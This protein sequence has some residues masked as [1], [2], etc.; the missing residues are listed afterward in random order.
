MYNVSATCRTWYSKGQNG[1]NVTHIGGNAYNQVC[2]RSRAT[3]TVNGFCDWFRGVDSKSVIFSHTQPMSFFTLFCPQRN[4]RTHTHT[5]HCFHDFRG[6]PKKPVWSIHPFLYVNRSKLLPHLS[7]WMFDWWV[8]LGGVM[9]VCVCV[10]SLS[11]WDSDV[12]VAEHPEV[13]GWSAGRGKPWLNVHAFTTDCQSFIDF[14]KH[15]SLFVRNCYGSFGPYLC[16]CVLMI[17]WVLWKE[18]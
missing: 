6:Q 7:L 18:R 17:I 11:G 8:H 2:T 14:R 9:L 10:C 4:A 1:H 12:L 3:Y 15:C 5:H 13:S 16:V